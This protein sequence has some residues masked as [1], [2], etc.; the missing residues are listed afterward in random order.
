MKKLLSI[1]LLFSIL[2]SGNAI[3]ANN[4]EIDNLSEFDLHKLDVLSALEIGDFT[5]E[6]FEIEVNI[7]RGE[8]VSMI[9]DLV[10]AKEYA[11]GDKVWFTDVLADNENFAKIS[12][13]AALGII[14]GY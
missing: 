4:T 9:A 10:A 8:F 1:I 2:I 14:S 5:K 11:E 13:A 12:G 6:D 3:Y 7:N